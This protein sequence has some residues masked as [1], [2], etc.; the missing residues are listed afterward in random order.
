MPL[1]PCDVEEKRLPAR[2]IVARPP[3]STPAV[4]LLPP[5]ASCR[6][7]HV[8]QTG[9]QVHHP[10]GD[11]AVDGAGCLA[12]AGAPSAKVG[13]K[14]LGLISEQGLDAQLVRF[15]LTEDVVALL[16]E[17]Q[18]GGALFCGEHGRI[19]FTPSDVQ[20]LDNAWRCNKFPLSDGREPSRQS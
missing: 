2:L 15:T 1:P 7:R 13:E 9:D 8:R 17:G 10:M 19:P 11:A 20:N 16:D 14:L 3:G 4:I 18:A 6:G 12:P 5:L